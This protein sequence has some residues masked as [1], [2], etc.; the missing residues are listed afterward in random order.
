MSP[1]RVLMPLSSRGFD[2]TETG[3]PWQILTAAPGVEV[4]FATPDGEP[5]EADSWML[6]PGEHALA[7]FGRWLTANQKGRAAYRAMASSTAFQSPIP[8]DDI[9][10]SRYDGL[11]LPGGHAPGIQ[12]YLESGVLQT[13]LV[14]FFDD[15]KPVGAI[16]HGVLMAAR[17]RRDGG[18]S[19]L[20]GYRTTALTR[21]MELFAWMLTKH[22]PTVGASGYSYRTY[23]G[24]T[25]ED[26]VTAALG[27]GA[28][29]P[30]PQALGGLTLPCDP[31]EWAAFLAAGAYLT[32]SFSNAIKMGLARDRPN[33]AAPA[34]IVEDGAHTV[35][36]RPHYVS[37][38]WPGDAFTFS[39]R[40]LAL[41]QA[42]SS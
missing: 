10:P 34:F 21:Q 28:F 13:R 2:P 35:S 32:P 7:P 38:R 11:L 19:V 3:V 31:G 15:R 41:L 36:G 25:V 26:E 24:T 18:T 42:A 4:E 5:G 6:K 29:D 8:Y 30:G 40:F 27:A 16:C 12:E 37:A 17:C 23:P 14:A 33:W 20:N 22:L 1:T 9:D 39:T